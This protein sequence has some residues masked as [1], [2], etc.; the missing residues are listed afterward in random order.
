MRKRKKSLIAVAFVFLLSINPITSSAHHGGSN[1]HTDSNYYECRAGDQ[2]I[3]RYQHRHV[4]GKTEFRV[5]ESI[6]IRGACLIEN[7]N[8]EK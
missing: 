4:N 8:L 6:G 7:E 2:W 3:I 1:W 5:H